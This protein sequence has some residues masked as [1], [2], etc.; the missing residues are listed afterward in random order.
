MK[1][2]VEFLGD[3]IVS[4]AASIMP[5]DSKGWNAGRNEDEKLSQIALRLKFDLSGVI[6]DGEITEVTPLIE[7]AM[8]GYFI[9]ARTALKGEAH[10]GMDN[11]SQDEKYARMV[12]LVPEWQERTFTLPIRTGRKPGEASMLKARV[13]TIAGKLDDIKDMFSRYKGKVQAELFYGIMEDAM[14]IPDNEWL[15]KKGGIEAS[16]IEASK[17]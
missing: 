13:K 9:D 15:A 11:K 3:N 7:R 4:V 14:D 16:L 17:K 8:D 10:L 1:Q 5:L 2:I 12:E 6:G